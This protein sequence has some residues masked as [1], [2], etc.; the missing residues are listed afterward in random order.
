MRHPAH[1]PVIAS[2]ATWSVVLGGKATG[3]GL[4]ILVSLFVVVGVFV[5]GEKAR[6]DAE[7]EARAL[8]DLE[9]RRIK[10]QRPAA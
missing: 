4:V 7:A 9:A 8:H 6:R 2:V 3:R 1:L 5:W 10:Q